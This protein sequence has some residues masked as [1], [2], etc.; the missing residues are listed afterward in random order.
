[1]GSRIGCRFAERKG[2][3]HGAS[4]RGA[5]ADAGTR[6]RAVRFVRVRL[7]GVLVAVVMSGCAA[8]PTLSAPSGP[9]VTVTG[10]PVTVT[11]ASFGGAGDG[12]RSAGDGD[13]SAAWLTD[14]AWH[15]RRARGVGGAG[16]QGPGSEDWL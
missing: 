6:S 4:L 9:T 13:C 1:M 14:E 8:S 5:V 11:A 15:R 10:P 16:G 2:L 12:H 3:R 7:G